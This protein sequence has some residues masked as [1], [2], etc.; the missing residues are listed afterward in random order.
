MSGGG[1]ACSCGALAGEIDP[2]SPSAGTH[3]ECFCDSCRATNVYLGQPDPRPGGV[4]LFQI[5]PDMIRITKGGEN[6]AA[7]QLT[8]KGPL[9]WYAACCNAPLFNTL[10]TANLPFA[11][12][13]VERLE[14]PA[15]VGPV[16]VQSFVRGKDGKQTHKGAAL[17]VWRLLTRMGAAR[18]S[19]RWK[20]TPFFDIGT[21]K[22]VAEPK[23]LSREERA[24]AMKG[25]AG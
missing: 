1:F 10:R 19:G 18:L 24:A 14:D 25:Q 12:L 20:E 16:R 8:P 3:V 15:R 23:L 5:T 13:M 4:D 17:M 22:P 9:R 21:G 7:L 11:T 2:L 6:L